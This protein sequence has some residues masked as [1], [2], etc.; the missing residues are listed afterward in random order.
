MKLTSFDSGRIEAVLDTIRSQ[1]PTVCDDVV[2]QVI[3][4]YMDD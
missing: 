4:S 1:N 3:A 2:A